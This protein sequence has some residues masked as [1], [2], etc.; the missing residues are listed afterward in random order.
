[1]LWELDPTVPISSLIDP[2][3]RQLGHVGY[4]EFTPTGQLLIGVWNE[5][6]KD[7]FWNTSTGAVRHTLV[8]IP[9]GK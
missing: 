3:N 5:S 8:G 9:R 2:E 7:G 4:M 1:M 6:K